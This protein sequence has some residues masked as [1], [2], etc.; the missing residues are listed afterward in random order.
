VRQ[1]LQLMFRHHFPNSA[2]DLNLLELP[3][4]CTQG[5]CTFDREQLKNQQALAEVRNFHDR[6]LRAFLF[7]DL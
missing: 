6:N 1:D 2:H 4:V 7:V 3:N 5:I